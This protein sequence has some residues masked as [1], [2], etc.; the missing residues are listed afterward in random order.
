MFLLFRVHGPSVHI[1]ENRDTSPLG[2]IPPRALRRS[3]P[4]TVR[5]RR[6]RI[7][8]WHCPAGVPTS[9]SARPR[10]LRARPPTSGFRTSCAWSAQERVREQVSLIYFWSGGRA[11]GAPPSTCG[12][13][14]PP[15]GCVANRLP[16]APTPPDHRAP[17][18]TPTANGARECRGMGVFTP[19]SGSW[20]PPPPP[21][22]TVLRHV[23]RRRLVP[24]LGVRN[25]S[26]TAL[27]RVAQQGAP[28]TVAR[29]RGKAGTSTVLWHAESPA[30]PTRHRESRADRHGGRHT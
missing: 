14:T 13:L 28:S 29:R 20:R 7:H 26:P 6:R 25:D 22:S 17:S 12:L 23:E 30:R 9:F 24:R 2:Q 18:R 3:P 19:D 21:A 16:V 1:G 11:C 5:P 8:H 4:G 27:R 10:W 15:G